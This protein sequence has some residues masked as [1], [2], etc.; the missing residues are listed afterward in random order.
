MALVPAINFESDPRGWSG[1]TGRGMRQP[2]LGHWYG[3]W[4]LGSAWIS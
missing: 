1:G 2:F 3:Q 4:S